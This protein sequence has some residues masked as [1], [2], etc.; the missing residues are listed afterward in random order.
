MT[1]GP[2]KR[3]L[4][5]TLGGGEGGKEWFDAK[6]MGHLHVNSRS[7]PEYLMFLLTM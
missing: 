1:T 5:V 6:K 7:E 4:S 2:R 3:D